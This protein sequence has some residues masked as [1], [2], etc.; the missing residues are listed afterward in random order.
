MESWRDEDER[1]AFGGPAS[2][3]TW[4]RLPAAAAQDAS[5][6]L[7]QLRRDEVMMDRREEPVPRRGGGGRDPPDEEEEPQMLWNVAVPQ[8][9]AASDPQFGIS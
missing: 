8:S 9:F 4:M 6:M 2:H 1:V 5:V 3:Q 7:C